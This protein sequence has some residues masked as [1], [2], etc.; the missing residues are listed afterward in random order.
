[1]LCGQIENKAGIVV[2]LA[3]TLALHEGSLFRGKVVNLATKEG[4]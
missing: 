4:G 2:R 3:R 1:M